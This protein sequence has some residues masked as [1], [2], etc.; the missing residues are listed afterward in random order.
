MQLLSILAEIDKEIS[1]LEQVRALLTGESVKRKPG[2]PKGSSNAARKRNISPEGRK[3]IGRQ[4][5]SAGHLKRRRADA[6]LLRL[7]CRYK[8]YA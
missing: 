2:P 7:P 8:D 5:G 4:S 6:R 3:R 1:T